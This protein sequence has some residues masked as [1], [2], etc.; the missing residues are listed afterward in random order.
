MPT[1]THSVL[2]RSGHEHFV[3]AFE[4]AAIGMAIVGLDG[5]WL[6]VNDAVV[7]I[8]GRS[9]DELLSLTFADITHPDDLGAD[10]EHVRRLLA[11][12]VRS[13]EMEKRYLRPD[14]RPTWVLLSVSLVR[15]ADGSPQHFISQIQ[16]IDR[17]RQA[18]DDLRATAERL[19]EQAHE[20]A[21]SNRDLEQFAAVAAHDLQEPLR[22]VQGFVQLLADRLEPDLDDT[23]REFVGYAIGGAE[24]M[25]DLIRDLLAFARVG[26]EEGPAEPCDVAAVTAVV[27]DQL[28]ATLA[29][30]GGEITI[31]GE[32][33]PVLAHPR[34]VLQLL[35]NLLSNAVKFHEAGRP[36]QVEVSAVRVGD[37]VR[38]TVADN[39][40]GVPPE[41]A[42]VVFEAT[43][44]LH[45]REA[46][47]G[48]GL[49]LAIC[50]SIVE[51]HGGEIWLEHL[52][53]GLAV[54]CT[55]P[56]VA[57]GTGRG[58]G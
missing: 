11:G 32:P 34:Q 49:G 31:V 58:A 51:R 38:V 30:V 17:R 22:T 13:Y 41:R 24:R 12:D 8:T 57:A 33:A 10:L 44:R 20:L 47:P 27:Q 25:G 1:T 54:H 9:A 14:G 23:T 35:Q 3:S 29:D 46:Y 19:A 45:A 55:L 6:E 21:R 40:I 53:Q 56:A 2:A 15:H 18:E 36:P 50:R 39:G 4:H 28:S 5:S 48:T 16:S 42:E 7:E 26:T 52:D 37:R 43:R